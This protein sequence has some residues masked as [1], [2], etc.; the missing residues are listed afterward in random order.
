MT[1]DSLNLKQNNTGKSPIAAMM[2]NQ[3][4]RTR[5]VFIKKFLLMKNQC[6]D[7]LAL[8]IREEIMILYKD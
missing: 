6:H 3:G 1:A 2:I 5:I 8:S 4:E 7:N